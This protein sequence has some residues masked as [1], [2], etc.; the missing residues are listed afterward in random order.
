MDRKTATEVIKSRWKELYPAD[1]HRGVICPICKSGSGKNGSGITEMK[2]GKHFLKCWNGGCEFNSGGSVIDLFMLENN[3]N[4]E[5]EF[6]KA[7]DI[8]AGRL[9]IKIDPYQGTGSNPKKENQN[10]ANRGTEEMKVTTV[11]PAAQQTDFSEYFK[12]CVRNLAESEEAQSYLQKRGIEPAIAFIANIGFDPDWKSPTVIRNQREKGNTWQ[13]NGKPCLIIPSSKYHYV[14]RDIRRKEDIPEQEQNYQ[15]MNEGT[16]DIFLLEQ[17]L[18][19]KP[20]YVFITEGGFDAL[21]LIEIGKWAIALNSTSNVDKLIKALEPKKIES[22][23]IICLDNDDSGKTAAKKLQAGLKRL[24]I[25]CID[26]DICN[27]YKDP[28]EALIADRE[29][30]IEKV[31]LSIRIADR[32]DSSSIYIDTIM[33]DDIKRRKEAGRKKTGFANLDAKIGGGLAPGLV[34]LGAGTSI[35]KTTFCSQLADSFA[36]GGHDVI[37][38]AM[39]QSRLEMIAKSLARQTA[40]I[41]MKKAVTGTDIVDGKIPENG[42]IQQAAEQYKKAVGD[43]VSIIEAGFNCDTAFIIN[44]IRNYHKRTGK[45]P[46]VFVDYLQILKPGELPNGRKQ[47]IRESIEECLRQLVLLKRELD[48]T[49]IAIVSINRSSYNESFHLEA[50]K[51]TGLAEF[52][53]DVVWG[54]QLS[55]L[56]EGKANEKT[57]EEEGSKIPRK[58]TL[59]ALKHRLNPQKYKVKFNYYPQYDLFVPDNEKVYQG[60]EDNSLPEWVKDAERGIK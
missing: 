39:E 17:T 25:S 21:S 20:E 9:N 40:K 44:Y 16:P 37:Y 23:F 7:V 10:S 59:K 38:F 29:G 52:S 2:N 26:A 30:F 31:D 3:M 51:E 15:K 22:T 46:V 28:N 58:V 54:L 8:L 50:I 13:P 55:C 35:G 5:T 27:G 42:I 48:L 32:P 6:S 57:I 11:N 41:D 19:I 18:E 47:D 1:K 24:N 45:R 36:A 49:I 33:G 34:L 53:A 43:R 56:D 14:A 60:E 12:E 4:P